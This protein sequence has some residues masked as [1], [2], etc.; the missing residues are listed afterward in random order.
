MKLQDQ[1]DSG[2]RYTTISALRSGLTS[3]VAPSCPFLPAAIHPPTLVWCCNRAKK[4][5]QE[6]PWPLNSSAVAHLCP[7]YR[8]SPSMAPFPA[9]ERWSDGE[10]KEGAA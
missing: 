2:G 10:S 3:A 5:A 8:S 6:P 4:C 1:I 9:R 7:S